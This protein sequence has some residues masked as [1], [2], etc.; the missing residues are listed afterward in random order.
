LNKINLAAILEKFETA[1]KAQSAAAQKKLYK[2][3]DMELLE[4]TEYYKLNS[5]SFANG[6][7]DLETSQFIYNKLNDY[8]KTTLAERMFITK[9]M[10][11]LLQKR[12]TSRSVV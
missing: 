2:S 10:Q 5:L 12:I 11:E 6:T 8:T 4:K 9:I 1:L 3:L 7:I